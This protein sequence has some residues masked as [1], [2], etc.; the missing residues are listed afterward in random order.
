[1]VRPIALALAALAGT[2]ALA[3]EPFTVKV[4]SCYDGDTCALVVGKM[5]T[6]AARD[7]GQVREAN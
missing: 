4:L 1:M 6:L 2:A 7:A 5:V 3:A